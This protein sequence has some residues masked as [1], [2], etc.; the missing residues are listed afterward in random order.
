MGLAD[1][2]EYP[3]VVAKGRV[4]RPRLPVFDSGN[5]FYSIRTDLASLVFVFNAAK[6]M[7]PGEQRR[8]RPVA[9]QT[10]ICLDRQHGHGRQRA[11]KPQGCRLLEVCT[12]LQSG[13]RT[14]PSGTL[15]T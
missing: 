12:W 3:R 4:T 13:F 2:P 10:W 11:T 8:A 6:K 9:P 5:E 1:T 15:V 7:F 14:G